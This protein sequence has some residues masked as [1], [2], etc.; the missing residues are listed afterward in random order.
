MLSSGGNI[1]GVAARTSTATIPI[2]AIASD[3]ERLGLV[4]SLN[5]P[6]GNVTGVSVLAGQ[7]DAKRLELMH[8]LLPTASVIAVLIN[9]NNPALKARRE[10][11]SQRL[12][13]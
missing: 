12:A 10:I 7:L 2:V 6:G 8:E 5:R 4:A 9:P 11:F 13:R 3:L 1:T